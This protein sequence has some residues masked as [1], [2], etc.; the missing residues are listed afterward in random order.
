MNN[1]FRLILTSDNQ[2]FSSPVYNN[3]NFPDLSPYKFCKV[4]IESIGL[5]VA[6]TTGATEHAHDF[7]SVEIA[8][9]TSGNT[10]I[11]NGSNTSNSSIIDIISGVL[12]VHQG[13]HN[14]VKCNKNKTADILNDGAVFPINIL[15]NNSIKLNLRYANGSAIVAPPAP[16]ASYK[17]ILGIQ[18]IKEE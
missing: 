12:E 10:Q 11:C 13:S 4:F 6:E 2:T 15:Q 17:I 5:T 7:I 3:L 1:Y 8:D 9:Y 18:L 14:V 16:H